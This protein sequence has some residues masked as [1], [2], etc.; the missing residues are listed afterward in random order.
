[1]KPPASSSARLSWSGRNSRGIVIA[2]K[3]YTSP[4]NLAAIKKGFQPSKLVKTIA[5]TIRLLDPS[6]FDQ[7]IPC[8]GVS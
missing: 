1:M 7:L 2:T 8:Q 6:L 3:N 4:F 5:L